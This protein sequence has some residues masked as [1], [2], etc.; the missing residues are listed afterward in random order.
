[1]ITETSE[2]Q[3]K[4]EGFFKQKSEV[5][6]CMYDVCMYVCHSRYCGAWQL[7][8]RGLGARGCIHGQNATR[9]MAAVGMHHCC[10]RQ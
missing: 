2:K 4:Q 5:D 9:I 6:V 10:L 7:E 1:M 8:E 3:V